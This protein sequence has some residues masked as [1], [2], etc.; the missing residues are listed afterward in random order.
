[1]NSLIFQTTTRTMTPLLLAFSLF[2]LLRG[3]NEPG[4]GF[5][6]GLLAVMAFVLYALA[7]GAP[8]ATRLLRVAPRTLTIVG[9]LLAI[10]SGCLAW[11]TGGPLMYGLWLPLTFPA[12]LKVGTVLL[13]DIGVYLVVLGAALLILLTLS[14][15]S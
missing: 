7:F 11:L 1:M 4:G 14:E 8:A 9:L 10:G 13:F 2:M 6:G 5:I 12:E 3:H 15:E